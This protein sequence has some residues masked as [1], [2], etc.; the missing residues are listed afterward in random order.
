ML[1]P[2]RALTLR[3]PRC[4]PNP[5]QASVQERQ[6]AAH[7][8]LHHH[9]PTP[10]PHPP[11]PHPPTARPP[12]P[13]HPLQG[14]HHRPSHHQR[15]EPLLLLQLPADNRLQLRA[16]PAASAAAAAVR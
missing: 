1:P 8:H 10:P 14:L 2:R 4:C 16:A 3:R 6:A 5:H 12:L 13:L 9:H 15:A 7:H 11:T